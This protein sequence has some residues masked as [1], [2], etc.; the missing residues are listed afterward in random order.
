MT[1][2]LGLRPEGAAGCWGRCGCCACATWVRSTALM[3]V[4]AAIDVPPSRMLR[5][6]SALSPEEFGVRVPGCLVLVPSAIPLSFLL[7]PD[8]YSAG[9]PL[10]THRNPRWLVEGSSAS[11]C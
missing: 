3:A 7:K 1:R 6:L 10:T 9:A 5:R 4:A 11:P 2:I 8:N